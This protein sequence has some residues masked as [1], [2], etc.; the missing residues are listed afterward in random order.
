M[1]SHSVKY[2][3]DGSNLSL[4]VLF[5]YEER[6]I[7]HLW[8][9]Q[10]GTCLFCCVPCSA[11]LD[12]KRAGDLSTLFDVGGIV[13]QWLFIFIFPAVVSLFPAWTL[14]QIGESIPSGMTVFVYVL[15]L[16]I[17]G[18]LAGLISDKLGKRATTCAVM[19]LLAAPT[20]SCHVLWYFVFCCSI[21]LQ[22][23]ILKINFVSSSSA[24][25][26]ALDCLFSVKDIML[27]F[28][29]MLI[30]WSTALWL[31]NDQPVWSGTNCW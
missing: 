10:T 30:F 6:Q 24:E 13:G 21:F 31:L 20:V 8:S 18:I 4:L 3:P 12:A 28:S 19:L 23:L 1:D 29:L 5:I 16:R 17:G 27:P 15:L 14:K 22:L 26:H 25:Q 2:K 11:H 7:K 9:N